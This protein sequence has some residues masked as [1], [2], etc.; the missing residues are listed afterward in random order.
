MSGND[1]L[2]RVRMYGGE[3]G[4]AVGVEPWGSHIAKPERVVDIGSAPK[5]FSQNLPRRV[6]PIRS[7][8][9]QELV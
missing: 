9:V 2:L 4:E 7:G 8:S 1:S 6:P 3:V 5:T